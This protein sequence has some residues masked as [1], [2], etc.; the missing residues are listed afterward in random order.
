MIEGIVRSILT[1]AGAATPLV[2]VGGA[3]N[4]LPEALAA[5][6][7]P[8]LSRGRFFLS[9][10]HLSRHPDSPLPKTIPPGQVLDRAR[11]LSE[12]ESAA[13]AAPRVLWLLPEI[14][15]V[16]RLS[17]AAPHTLAEKIIWHALA[18]GRPVHTAGGELDPATWPAEMPPTMRRGRNSAEELL[19]EARTRLEL[20]GMRFHPRAGSL[21]AAME[22]PTPE[23]E[24]PRLLPLTI[25][26]DNA[27]KRRF[28][29]AEDIY[30]LREE[31]LASWRVPPGAILTDQARD[32]A[33]TLSIQLIEE[34]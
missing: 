30:K 28:I 31:G 19:S 4:G 8:A 7:T 24:T 1:G 14:A 15:S 5:I 18:S 23:P 13:V 29:L 34:P 10:C 17:Q 26:G 21:I 9:N 16:V 22:P 3:A 20:W 2:V 25:H 11:P 33:A 32:V 6:A 27:P 12:L